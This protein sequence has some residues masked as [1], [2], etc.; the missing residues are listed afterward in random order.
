MISCIS[1]K[2]QCPHHPATDATPANESHVHKVLSSSLDPEPSRHL[3]T[4]HHNFSSGPASASDASCA[5]APLFLLQLPSRVPLSLCH[6]PELKEARCAKVESCAARH[7]FPNAWNKRCKI[8]SPQGQQPIQGMQVSHGPPHT[9]PTRNF[10]A[11]EFEY[12]N[13]TAR[14]VDAEQRAAHF[15][16]LPAGGS[17]N[18]CFSVILSP[19]RQHNFS[20]LMSLQCEM[21]CRRPRQQA[22]AEHV[23]LPHIA[24]I[25]W[26]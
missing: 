9:T 8:E 4:L 21:G 26:A 20:V 19:A 2:T 23:R 1:T 24:F 5:E 12:V 10:H 25:Q 16:W 17:I 22:R 6:D 7:V 15:G 3:S 13:T 18:F 11:R 14:R